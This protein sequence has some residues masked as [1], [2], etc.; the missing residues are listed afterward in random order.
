MRY[1]LD[2]NRY[3]AC[4]SYN[5][6]LDEQYSESKGPLDILGYQPRPSEVLFTMSPDTYEAAFPDFMQQREETIKDAVFNGFP[7]PI[8]Y[9]LYRFE[10]GYENELQRL[11][12]LR[13]TWEAVVDVLHGLAIAELRHRQIT[14]AEPFKFKNLLTDSVSQRIENIEEIIK[15]IKAAGK[16]PEFQRILS[17][18]TLSTMRELNQSR[19]AFS[20][21][22][23]QSE[24]QSMGWINE[25]RADVIEILGDLVGLQHMQIVRYL[26]QPDANTMRC[27]TF[28]G[29]SAAKT[30]KKFP[31]SHTH[32]ADSSRYF[33]KDHMLVILGN[34]IFSLRPAIHFRDD[35]NG[36][37]TRLCVLRKTHGD[38]PNRT[39]EYAVIGE[40]APHIM[41]RSVFFA[42]LT[43]IRGLFR[44]GDD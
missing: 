15:Q 16:T 13:D 4:P 27:E 42:E 24:A 38:K 10:N 37:M 35:A 32:M 5:D 6:W 17:A 2:P 40:A 44:L 18:T 39:I 12:F 29:H 34:E 31:L 7:T 25:C 36:H 8:A 43:E 33:Q 1:Q 28:K 3:D 14:M 9:Y 26:D 19:N 30:I 23:A 41:D 21:L 22:A 20:H 11:H